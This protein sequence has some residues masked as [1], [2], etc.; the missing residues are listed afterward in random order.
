MIDIAVSN[1]VISQFF[2]WKYNGS[3]TGNGWNHSEYNGVW[4]VDYFNRTAAA[5]S[6]MFT[7]RDKEVKNFYTDS[8]VKG[9]ALHGSKKYEITFPAGQEPPVHAFWSLTLYNE[10][11]FFHQNELKR[12]SLGTKSSD[13]K[14]ER[15]GS[16]TIY[17][18]AESPGS[19]K[20]SNWLPSPKGL[21][22]LY[23]RCYWGKKPIVDGS[24]KPPVVVEVE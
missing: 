3:P 19:A 10:N 4:G 7:K 1:K 21:F 15:D 22:S 23:L 17:I 13:M 2:K 18:S 20:E 6:N 5:R 8:D 24:W 16:F 12:Y 14:R 11:H 9:I